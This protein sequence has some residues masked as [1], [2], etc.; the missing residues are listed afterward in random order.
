MTL[1][2]KLL[3][4]ALKV[5]GKRSVR[6]LPLIALAFGYSKYAG[7][8]NIE[9]RTYMVWTIAGGWMAGYAIIAEY[10][11]L[12]KQNENSAIIDLTLFRERHFR[13]I[14]GRNLFLL[15]LLPPFLLVS[16]WRDSSWSRLTTQIA[17]AG[18]AI[19][20]FSGVQWIYYLWSGNP[21]GPSK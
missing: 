13:R 16:F 4:A 6:A 20:A 11:K 15:L 14:L 21:H 3:K 9:T 10:W 1:D 5:V 19:L 8:G 18:L 7:L 17:W 2:G 12:S